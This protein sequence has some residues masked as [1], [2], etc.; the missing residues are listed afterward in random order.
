[1]RIR[2][3]KSRGVEVNL[4]VEVEKERRR[5]RRRRQ[6]RP[7]RNRYVVGEMRRGGERGLGVGVKREEAF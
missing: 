3:E 5:R 1:M 7:P 6:K 2:K 4:A